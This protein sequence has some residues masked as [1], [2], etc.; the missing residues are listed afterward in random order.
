MIKVEQVS[1]SLGGR[2]IVEDVSL[3]IKDGEVAGLLGPNGAGKTT[4][5]R[6][7]NGVI[8]PDHGS[9]HINGYSASKHGK[10]IRQLAGVM[11]ESA[12]LY[13]D[14]TA[15]ENLDFFARL[16]GVE[17]PRVRIGQLLEQ[18]RLE[19]Y[20]NKLV[21]EYST[22]MKKRLAIAKALLHQPKLLYLDEPTNGLDPDGIREMMLYL[23]QLNRQ[24][25]TTIIICSHVL[26]QLEEVCGSFLFLDQG[27][28]VESG[29]LGEL[30]QRYAGEVVLRVETGLAASSSLL[31][32]MYQP[33]ETRVGEIEFTL[34]GKE[35]ISDLLRLLL[36]HSWVHHVQIANRS[37]ESIYFEVRRRVHEQ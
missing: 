29:T 10:Q 9:I 6:L 26:Y 13:P 3:W 16:Y 33:R 11:T 20:G 19:S 15:R 5:I 21:G 17:I 14:M 1:K 23:R 37:L 30:E 24:E 34:P 4:M 18:F 36:L 25:G 28:I 7:M 27:R 12:G 32:A 31:P 8:T 35:E 22:G 2:R